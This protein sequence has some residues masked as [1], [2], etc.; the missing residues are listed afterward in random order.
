M[1]IRK[2]D[3]PKAPELRLCRFCAD[4][5]EPIFDFGWMPIANGFLTKEQV[6]LEKANVSMDDPAWGLGN[7]CYR[8]ILCHCG[9]CGLVQLNDQPNRDL[10]FH[11]D[12][13]FRTGTS[14][15][16]KDHFA[17]FARDLRVHFFPEY[18]DQPL[19]LDIG[20][21][22]GTFL[23]SVL[24]ENPD[25]ILGVVGVEPSLAPALEAK[26]K[27]IPVV[28]AFFDNRVVRHIQ[29][30]YGQPSIIFSSNT[31]C[32]VSDINNFFKNIKNLLHI[33][34]IFVTEDPYLWSIYANVAF[35]QIYDE[36]VF[37][38]DLN[39]LSQIADRNGLKIVLCE[40]ID[41]HG[42]SMR[43]MF[44]HKEIAIPINAMET[45]KEV[46]MFE[47]RVRSSSYLSFVKGTIDKMNRLQ[48]DIKLA[49]SKRRQTTMKAKKHAVI[50]Y[51]ATSKATLILNYLKL[52]EKDI[53]GVI[54]N[55]P[56]KIGKFYPGTGIP[57]IS[58][59][60]GIRMNPDKVV[61]FAWNHA[62][63]IK[64]KEP[65]FEGKWLEYM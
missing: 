49:Q 18:N 62:D 19:I 41:V 55:T 33:N 45:V 38:F 44:T 58:R 47:H 28:N 36:H 12:Y 43:Y 16:M 15:G 22:D 46:A 30:M 50:G 42:G 54:D 39:S 60:E 25:K 34:G 14:Q 11:K 26:R 61:L 32:H 7:Y 48:N 56:E 40:P 13:P 1:P 57:V 6:E 27:G 3:N 52:T 2:T 35:D 53:A 8:L 64:A 21:N 65:Q 51:G 9:Y 20:C 37:Y 10:L 23:E 5:L 29:T 24:R 17:A 63:E 59:E 31:V 4:V